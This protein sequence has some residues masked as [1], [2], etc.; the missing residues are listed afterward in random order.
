M[1]LGQR[2]NRFERMNRFERDEPVRRMC[3]DGGRSAVSGYA[4]G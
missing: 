3:H 1:S 4:G 2:I